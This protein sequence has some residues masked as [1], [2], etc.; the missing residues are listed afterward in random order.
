MCRRSSGTT[1]FKAMAFPST[2]AL[3]PSAII[4]GILRIDKES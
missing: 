1:T 2:G 4:L 3:R